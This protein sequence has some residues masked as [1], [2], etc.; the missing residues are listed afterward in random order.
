MEACVFKA[1]IIY[2]QRTP[3]LVRVISCYCFPFHNVNEG[4]CVYNTASESY[5][6]SLHKSHSE[7]MTI[8]GELCG[9]RL[10]KG[11]SISPV[12]I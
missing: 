5:I 4:K 12:V 8:F 6:R 2:L 10:Q 9:K 3:S 1:E 7:K 11:V